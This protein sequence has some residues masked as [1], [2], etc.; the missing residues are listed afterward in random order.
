MFS[1]LLLP[2]GKK[3]ISCKKIISSR[4][5]SPK[6]QSAEVKINNKNN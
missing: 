2:V 5:V 3:R 4:H 1:D 6:K